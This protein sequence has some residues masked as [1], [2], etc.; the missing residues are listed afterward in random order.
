VGLQ[1]LQQGKPTPNPYQERIGIFNRTVLELP[2]SKRRLGSWV[3]KSLGPEN[4]TLAPPKRE[5]SLMEQQSYILGFDFFMSQ[6]YGA[7]VTTTICF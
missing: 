5:E 6:P 7:N 4:P 2:P 1:A 3:Y